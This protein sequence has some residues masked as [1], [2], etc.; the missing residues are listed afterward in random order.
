MHVVWNR[1]L[2]RSLHGAVHVLGSC[3]RNA[4]ER[5]PRARV[6]RLKRAAAGRIHKLPA[7]EELHSSPE[8]LQ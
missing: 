1:H 3:F 8:A 4:H 7:Y 2:T 6:K 5:L